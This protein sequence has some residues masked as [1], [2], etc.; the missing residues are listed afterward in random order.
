MEPAVVEQQQEEV[1]VDEGATQQEVEGAQ[2]GA[3]EGAQKGAKEGEEVPPGE[4]LTK[5]F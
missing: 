5:N 2:K 3:E 4:A 1:Q